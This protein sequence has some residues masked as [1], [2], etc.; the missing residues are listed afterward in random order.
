MQVQLVLHELV[1][2]EIHTPILSECSGMK[3]SL[4]LGVISAL[5]FRVKINCNV[6]HTLDWIF[7]L[8]FELAT[9]CT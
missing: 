9:Q 2:L 3:I 5:L 8:F 7:T 4:L 1:T 6:I